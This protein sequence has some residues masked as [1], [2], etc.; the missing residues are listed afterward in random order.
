M[1]PARSGKH[2]FCGNCVSKQAYPPPKESGTNT[3]EKNEKKLYFFTSLLPQTQTC[4]TT[5]FT[6]FFH[7]KGHHTNCKRPKKNSYS[8]ISSSTYKKQTLHE[9]IYLQMQ[10]TGSQY[11]KRT[12]QFFKFV[13]VEY[14]FN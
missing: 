4:T 10:A 13:Q 6:K 7:A 14:F 3:D 11:F 12:N 9:S 5:K 8:F 2:F 1:L